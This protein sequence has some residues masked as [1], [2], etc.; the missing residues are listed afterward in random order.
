MVRE[1]ALK[2]FNSR[3]SQ[4]M[5][6]KLNRREFIETT[7]MAGAASAVVPE[8]VRGRDPQKGVTNPKPL[9]SYDAGA[10]E[11][12]AKMTLDEKIGQM[13]QAEQDALQSVEDIE[14]YF[15][16][17]LLSGGGS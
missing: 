10:R 6:R 12:L 17:S 5:T 14:K 7:L 13:T 1:L 9:M 15:L 11:L 4:H 3:R 8:L 2:A 16:G